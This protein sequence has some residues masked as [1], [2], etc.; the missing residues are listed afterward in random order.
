[1]DGNHFVL[2]SISDKQQSI[3]AKYPKPHAYHGC[4]SKIEII[5]N[6]KQTHQ[7]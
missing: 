2:D 6:I 1:M 7:E 5:T 4:F 3:I